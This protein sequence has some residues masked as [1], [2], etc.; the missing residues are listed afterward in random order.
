MEA[1]ISNHRAGVAD[2]KLGRDLTCQVYT[3]Q[4]ISQQLDLVIRGAGN[5]SSKTVTINPYGNRINILYDKESGWNIGTIE[6]PD[7][8]SDA[9]ITKLYE[10]RRN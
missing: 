3:S 2:T 5:T 6:P 10:T 1:D 4:L 8:L 7:L 9:P